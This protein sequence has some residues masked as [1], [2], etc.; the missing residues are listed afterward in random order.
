MSSKLSRR[1]LMQGAGVAAL[2]AQAGPARAAMPENKFEG[3]DTPKICLIAG[4]GAFG[5]SDDAATARHIKQLG[6]NHVIAGA[7]GRLPWEESRLKEIIE[8][9][10]SYGLSVGNMMIGGFNNAI[11]ARPGRD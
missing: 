5:G 10:K 6:I 1:R 11:Y 8:R 3:K 7:G 2:A 4:D 9:Y